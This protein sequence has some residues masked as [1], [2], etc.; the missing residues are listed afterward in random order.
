[1]QMRDTKDADLRY[2]KQSFEKAMADIRDDLDKTRYEVTTTKEQKDTEIKR[3][4]SEIERV[5]A[6][7]DY[8]IER[9]KNDLNRAHDEVT[10]AN[11]S[12]ERESKMSRDE[13]AKVIENKHHLLG[14]K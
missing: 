3:L 14:G 13:I 7:R 2:Q 11:E 12:R 5:S 10:K 9:L 4:H 8:A 1:M 6:D